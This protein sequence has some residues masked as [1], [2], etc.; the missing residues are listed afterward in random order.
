M[1]PGAVRSPFST[2]LIAHPFSLKSSFIHC[3]DDGSR[4]TAKHS[5][6]TPSPVNLPNLL[7]LQLPVTIQNGC[8]SR[9]TSTN[10]LRIVHYRRGSA[11]TRTSALTSLCLAQPLGIYAPRMTV[12]DWKIAV[13]N[14]LSTISL[15][16]CSASRH[17]SLALHPYQQRAPRASDSYPEYIDRERAFIAAPDK[18][19]VC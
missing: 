6:S 3:Q 13:S 2:V 12:Q 16:F 7:R 10:E 9:S 4:W 14:S 18:L 11:T 1:T 19:V 8:T 17:R 15:L 5:W